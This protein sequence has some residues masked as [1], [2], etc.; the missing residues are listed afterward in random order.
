MDWM[1]P[2]GVAGSTAMT[3]ST[4][5]TLPT[6]PSERNNWISVRSLGKT[7]CVVKLTQSKI[8]PTTTSDWVEKRLRGVERLRED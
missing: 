7:Q 6:P 2:K 4:T 1:S 8:D 5:T 3:Q